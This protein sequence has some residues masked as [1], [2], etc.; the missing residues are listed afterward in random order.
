M[1]V[2]RVEPLG[3]KFLRAKPEWTKRS[4]EPSV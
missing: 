3:M 2:K 1:S 4:D